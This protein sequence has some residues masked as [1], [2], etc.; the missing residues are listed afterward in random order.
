MKKLLLILLISS[1][2]SCSNEADPELDKANF[3]R[4]FNSNRYNASYNPIDIKQTADGGYL[5]LAGRELE[6]SNFSG[7]Y[8]IKTD[9]VGTFE[10]EF[11]VDETFVNPVGELMLA[12]ENFYFFCMTGVNLQTQL[13][14]VSQAGEINQVINVGGTYPSA[15][16]MDGGNFL[17]LGYDNASKE[18]V[19]SIV[20]PA[21]AVSQSASFSIGAGDA[22][23]EPIINHFIR[24]GRKYP[25]QVGK[26]LGG[27][28]FFNGFYNYTFSLV[29]TDLSEIQGVVQGQQ[30]DGGIS[31]LLNTTG[32]TFATA[33]FNF[34]D[35]Y[36]IPNTPI[37][38][39]GVSSSTDLPGFEL[40]ELTADAPV[41]I[42]AS[43]IKNT[44]VLVYASNT[45][46]GQIGLY[47]YDRASGDFLGTKYLGFSNPY[48]VSG[49][50]NTAD[51]GILV[52]GTTYVA[53]RFP[54]ITLFK[55]SKE[56]LDKVF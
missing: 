4:I 3:T 43:S 33:R 16:A 45:K 10:S 44:E 35:N 15:A 41:K 28:Y 13:V 56:E 32:N 2:W 19:L 27:Q 9:N 53:G 36:F 46:G 39:S 49:V 12:N 8:I 25:F 18:T 5:V 30:D 55:L 31:Y 29:F 22:V 6:N 47:I 40:L 7:I 54:R 24:T 37:N 11:I 14:E 51:E 26:T 17:L 52:C 42:L 20:S 21:G 50:I 34:G 38:T 48:E 1:A 23:E